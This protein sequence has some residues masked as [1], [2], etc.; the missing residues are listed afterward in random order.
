MCSRQNAS[1]ECASGLGWARRV[2]RQQLDALSRLKAIA[3][4][5]FERPTPPADSSDLAT[6]FAGLRGLEKA[7]RRQV[8]VD[9]ALR[10]IGALRDKLRAELQSLENGEDP[11][12]MAE[13]ANLAAE[14]RSAEAPDPKERPERPERERGERLK[15]YERFDF[16][17]R[18]ADRKLA[19]IL[20]R[21]TAEIIALICRQLGL[22][23]DW[24][25]R[26][27]EAWEREEGDGAWAEPPRHSA[28]GPLPGLPRVRAA[29]S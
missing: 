21:P 28:P 10:L 1:V 6:F 25:R 17:G 9:W 27:E 29:P 23:A 8:R 22:P 14:F 15:D 3:L 18:A 4:R 16:Q 26:A 24:L 12:T 5:P 7:V 13:A 11:K 2:L 19:E 20:K